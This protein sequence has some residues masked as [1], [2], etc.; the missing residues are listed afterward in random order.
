MNSSSPPPNHLTKPTS[1][2]ETDM[3]FRA[4]LG[5]LAQLMQETLYKRALSIYEPDPDYQKGLLKCHAEISSSVQN[6]LG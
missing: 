4:K 6:V 5:R 3:L 2:T 1:E